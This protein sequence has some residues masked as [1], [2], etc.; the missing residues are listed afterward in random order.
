MRVQAEHPI[1]A[2]LDMHIAGVPQDQAFG[3]LLG[4]YAEWRDAFF[5]NMQEVALMLEDL[6][7]GFTELS[8][9]AKS[10]KEMQRREAVI[11]E[12]CSCV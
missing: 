5:Q 4:A 7:R 8:A 9:A 10:D 6:E 12:V 1:R 3:Q 11:K 2:V